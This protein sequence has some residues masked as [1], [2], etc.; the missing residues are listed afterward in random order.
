VVFII[1]LH[2]TIRT[3]AAGIIGLWAT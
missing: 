3:L 1:Q 2:L